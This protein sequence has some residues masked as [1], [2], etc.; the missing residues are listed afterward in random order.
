MS[1]EENKRTLRQFF[2]AIDR[3]DISALDR[4]LSP[5]YIDHNPPPMPGMA[6]GLEGVKQA[7]A[8][9]LDAFPDTS[10]TIEDLLADGDKVVARVVGRGTHRASFMGAPP[11]GREVTMEGI[12]IYRFAD[13]KIVEKWG[14]QD[15]LGIMQQLGVL[16]LPH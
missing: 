14:Q 1:V 7:F 13:G 15:R 4:F 9:F 12:A 16:P 2:E 11:S 6:S 5:G 8:A 10:H 3:Q